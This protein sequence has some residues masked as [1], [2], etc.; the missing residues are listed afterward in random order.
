M[1]LNSQ[2]KK[3]GN[4]TRKSISARDNWEN[5]DIINGSIINEK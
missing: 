3:Q 1:W 2:I 4:H 5:S